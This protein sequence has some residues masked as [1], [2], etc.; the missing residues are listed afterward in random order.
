MKDQE[1]A[2]SS[3]LHEYFTQ[4]FV[5]LMKVILI[6]LIDIV[7]MLIM[8]WCLEFK[9]SKNTIAYTKISTDNFRKNVNSK[10]THSTNL[11]VD[12]LCFRHRKN[13]RL[14]CDIQPTLKRKTKK[15]TL[16]FNW[17]KEKETQ[18]KKKKIR[19]AESDF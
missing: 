5:V 18:C 16:V 17:V 13:A 10:I 14:L 2:L 1:E 19:I 3:N 6:W 8:L 15:F 4:K 9:K 12:T 11:Q 7:L